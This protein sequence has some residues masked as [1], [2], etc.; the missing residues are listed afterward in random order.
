MTH[1]GSICALLAGS[2]SLSAPIGSANIAFHEGWYDKDYIDRP[3]VTVT[4]LSRPVGL[5]FLGTTSVTH[6]M[7]FVVN[8][9]YTIPRGAPGT[10]EYTNIDSMRVEAFRILNGYRHVISDLD[11]SLAEDEGVARHELD[12]IPRILR[13]ELVSFAVD[14]DL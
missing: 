4:D 1:A 13:Y 10:L 5:F 14:T 12:Q 11:I 6:H 9:W 7:R 8:C 3:Q 2:W